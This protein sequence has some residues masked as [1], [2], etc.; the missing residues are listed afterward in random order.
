MNNWFSDM[1]EN[2]MPKKGSK[3]YDQAAEL[4]EGDYVY[5]SAELIQSSQKGIRETSL[6]E[7]GS[8]GSPEFIVRFTDI[9]PEK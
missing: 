1:G 5:F 4:S 2:T 9:R 3:I 6:T 7:S 8:L